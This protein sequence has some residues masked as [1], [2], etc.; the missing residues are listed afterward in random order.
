MEEFTQGKI[1]LLGNFIATRLAA[2]T[3]L[4]IFTRSGEDDI[5]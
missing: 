1:H 3:F 5:E 2:I 4:N